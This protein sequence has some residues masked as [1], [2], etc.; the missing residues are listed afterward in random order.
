MRKS[1]VKALILAIV[2]LGLVVPASAALKTSAQRGMELFQDPGFA[3]GKKACNS[4]HPGGQRLENAGKKK[5]F[6]I[7][8]ATQ[9]SLEE[10]VNFCIVNANKG[11]AIAE[12]SR[13]MK[14]I[15][16][17]IKSLGKKETGGYGAPATG[18]YGAPGYKAPGYG[19]KPATGGYGAPGYK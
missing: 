12:D 10:A 4:C 6:N 18:G 1:F 15:V 9:N 19:T 14:D 17:Y 7:M 3:S 13:Q 11:K 5:Q 2:A 8:G 16:I